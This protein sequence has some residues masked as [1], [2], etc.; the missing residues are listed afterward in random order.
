LGRIENRLLQLIAGG[1]NRFEEL[2]PQFGNAE[3][4][5]GYGDF[6]VWLALKGMS[7]VAEPLLVL[8]GEEDST[9]PLSPARIMSASFEVTDAGEKILNGAADAI[10]LN[11]IDEWLG[12]VHLSGRNLWRWNDQRREVLRQSHSTS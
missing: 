9:D 8:I 4:R 11:G 2:F 5:Y 1:L 7:D 6:Q 10:E 3:P 12:G